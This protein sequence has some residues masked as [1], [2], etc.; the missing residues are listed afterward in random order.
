[1]ASTHQQDIRRARLTPE[2]LR[3]LLERDTEGHAVLS[4]Y[5]DLEPSQ[6]PNLRERHMQASSLLAEVEQRQEQ[7][8]GSHEQRM[9][10]RE[11][12]ARVRELLA[13]ESELAPE[14]ARSLAIFCSTAAGIFEVVS[15]PEGV[16]PH[17]SIDTQPFV[18]PLIEQAAR[19]S[20]C[21]LLVSH[22]ASRLFLGDR[23]GLLQAASLL[24]DVH[25]HHAQGGWAQ[26]RY[27]RSVEKEAADHIRAT[28]AVLFELLRR[29]PF[30]RLLIG[31]PAEL[32]GRVEREL[33]TDA[34]KR[35][36][37]FFE[38]DVERAGLEDVRHRVA[39]LIEADERERERKALALVREGLAPDGH[40]AVGLDEVLE[41]LNERRV[42]TLLLAHG[43]ALPGF[44]CPGCGRLAT[45][46]RP[47]PLD[48]AAPVE[49]A[50]IT[51]SLIAA[52]LRQDAEILM[53]HH[54]AAEL[55]GSPAALT[56]Y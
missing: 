19:T 39:P 33:H 47:C 13:E 42:Q 14:D 5:L 53:I 43:L 23:D 11:D 3:G 9:A 24:D 30:E 49:R 22:R 27:Q 54:E 4:L 48:G 16:E 18:A 41:L 6:Q 34:R 40:A 20:F 29:H 32:H 26:A 45:E 55:G 36:A 2:W 37:G 28:C 44:V 10:A 7:A 35:L 51:E 12:I 17:A 31:G 25:K 38:V 21:V 15:L 1:M 52:A 46:A 56:R 50:D 8:G